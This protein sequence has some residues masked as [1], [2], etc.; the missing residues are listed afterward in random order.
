MLLLHQMQ[1][2]PAK[3]LDVIALLADKPSEKLASGQMGTIVEVLTP[4]AFEVEFCDSQGNTI[5]LTELRRDEFLVLHHEP[6]ATE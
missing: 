6:V 3:L 2:T 1:N 5:G 4:N